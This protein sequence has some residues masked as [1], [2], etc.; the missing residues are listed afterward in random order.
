MAIKLN[1]L[2]PELAVRGGVVKI[3]RVLT[4]L[5]IAAIAGFIIF[6]VGM[7]AF[8]V[9]SSYELRSLSTTVSKLKSEVRA[10]E[11]TEQKI[12]LL[13]DRVGKIRSLSSYDSS[14]KDIVNVESV[15]SAVGT[16]TSVGQLGVEPKKIDLSLVFK[17]PSELSNFIR[18]VTDSKIYKNVIMPSLGFSPINGYSISL[19]FTQK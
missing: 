16:Q 15:L 17:D 13:K 19:G 5:A 2:P 12:V 18:S 6:T 8:F 1:L 10:Q 7:I 11:S 4:S 14:D 9:V 3:A